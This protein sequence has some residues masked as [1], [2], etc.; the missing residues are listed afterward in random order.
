MNLSIFSI[1]NYYLYI[2][3]ILNLNFYFITFNLLFLLIVILSQLISGHH[4]FIYIIHYNRF[5]TIS[6]IFPLNIH[7]IASKFTFI[8]LDYLNYL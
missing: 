5:I 3:Y 8:F 1:T 6:I 4:F 2:L 7:L